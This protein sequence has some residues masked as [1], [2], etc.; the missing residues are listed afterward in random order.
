MMMRSMFALMETF[1]G[2]FQ[3]QEVKNIEALKKVV[4]ENTTDYYPAPIVSEDEV[5]TPE[6]VSK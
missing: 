3:A 2:A 1:G 5:I 4:E 6:E